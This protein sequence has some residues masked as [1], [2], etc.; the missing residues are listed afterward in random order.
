MKVPVPVAGSRTL[1]SIRPLPKWVAQQVGAF[2]HEADDLVGGIDNAQPVG[3]LGI[4][5]LV[6]AFID[7]LEELLLL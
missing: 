3:G 6:E 7:D 4:V 5:D 1:G 2:D